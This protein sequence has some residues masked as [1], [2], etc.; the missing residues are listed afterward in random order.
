MLTEMEQVV[1]SYPKIK[2]RLED[3]GK[4]KNTSKVLKNLKEIAATYSNSTIT[5]ITKFL[6]I[7]LTKMY[8]G[9]NINFDKNVNL[10][11][12]VAENHVI[13][14]PNHQSHADYIA[15][16]YKIFK[17]YNI[18][19]YSAGGKNLDIFPIG[20]LFRNSGC[21]FIRRS[22]HNDIL[23]KLTLEAYLF[24]LLGEGKLIEFFFEGGRSRNGKLLPPRF[25]LYHMLLES[26]CYL[27]KNK[28]KNLLFLP[29]SIVH[30]YV[31]EQKALARELAGDKKTKE[32]PM[33]LLKLFK[34][35]S[36]QLGSIHINISAPINSTFNLDNNIKTF[37]QDLAFDCFRAVGARMVVTPTSLL[38]LILLDAP[39]G[40][41][42]WEE[43][44]E[45]ADSILK[46][47]SSFNI[48]ITTS[49]NK[50]NVQVGLERAL[51]ILIN[52]KKI[53]VIGSTGQGHVFYSINKNSRMEIL[54]FKNTIIHHFLV[55][56]IINSSLNDLF[57]GKIKTKKDLSKKFLTL[58]RQL[59][60]EFYLP[61]VKQ[62]FVKAMEIISASIKR[63][64]KDLDDC[65]GLSHQE[66]FVLSSQLGVFNRI[67][68]YFVEGYFLV[69]PFI[70]VLTSDLRESFE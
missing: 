48:P 12:L 61:T 58:R 52:N 28:K 62:F 51:D 64:V 23:Y 18:P 1:L 32:T 63:D 59:K 57:G 21:F 36:Y 4:D 69:I 42:K 3:Q 24:Y 27:P 19:T 2:K 46:F 55:P 47:C 10:K 16:N 37:T 49:L 15:L 39:V 22:F 40:A 7:S 43:I 30:E 17:D 45:K 44:K 34:L 38:A 33:Q 56:W 50:K 53:D 11:K 26:H 70:K 9:I 31:P 54:Y 35:F 29:V 8:D 25:G 5:N 13:L 68:N 60:Y 14:V 6:D 20:K 41:M 67:C 66:L 65:L